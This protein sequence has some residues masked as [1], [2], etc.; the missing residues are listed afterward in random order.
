MEG[1]TAYIGQF[2]L[3]TYLRSLLSSSISFSYEIT[4]ASGGVIEE[5]KEN[6]VLFSVSILYGRDSK[7]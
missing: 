4:R 6:S 7:T 5:N 2:D 3:K 1:K